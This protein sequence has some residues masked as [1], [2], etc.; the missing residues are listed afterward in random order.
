MQLLR[1]TCLQWINYFLGS[2][3]SF[4]AEQ[5]NLL[6]IFPPILEAHNLPLTGLIYEIMRKNRPGSSTA[7]GV[8]TVHT[9][10]NW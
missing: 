1:G 8:F 3:G 9:C 5:I 6:Q 10:A 2:G 7:D 4:I